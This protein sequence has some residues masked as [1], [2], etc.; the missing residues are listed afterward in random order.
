M[1][2]AEKQ[3]S[4]RALVAPV[5]LKVA[6]KTPE[7]LLG[8]LT[9]SVGRGGVRIETAR[10]LPVGTR[11]E[12][13]LRS[14]GVSDPV[15]V[16]GTVVTTS[17][18][19]PGRWV[20]HIRYEALRSRTGIEAVLRRIFETAHYD[21]RRKSP[22]IPLRVRATSTG[23]DA[24]TYRLRDLSTGGVGVDVEGDRLP[25]FVQVGTP[26]HLEVK[27][28]TGALSLEG[29]V[30]WADTTRFADTIPPRLG[31]AFRALDARARRMLEDL[32]LLKALPAPPWIAKMAFGGQR[33]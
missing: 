19:R 15:E 13:E 26:F 12:F 25:A 5:R 33:P 32:L 31:V 27:L 9:R 22:R 16:T 17:E 10:S 20:M 30:V 2:V 24:P 4:E 11:F 18:T 28:M 8:E 23:T 14:P 21:K 29:T 1:G 7:S 3:Q 6:Y